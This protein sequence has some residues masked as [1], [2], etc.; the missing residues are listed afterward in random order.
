MWTP[1]DA[2]PPASR[3]AIPVAAPPRVRDL[4]RT[5]PDGPL[6]VLHRGPRAIY[7]AVG[8]RAV[9]LLAQT[10]VAV[11]NGLRSTISQF[12]PHQGLSAYSGSGVLHVD[13]RPLSVRRIVG[14]HIPP[15][16][17]ARSPSNT[18]SSATFAATPP[19]A[20]AEFVVSEAPDGIDAVAVA[21]LVGRGEGLTPLG[22]DVL[23]GWLA[24]HRA[25][26]VA[27]PDVDATVRAHA[28]RTT[29]LSATLLD[30]ALHG[31]GLPE[32]G[33]WLHALGSRDES[34]AATALLAV[35]GTSGAGLMA[36]AMLALEALR[37][38]RAPEVAA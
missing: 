19:A 34:P 20:V 13:G 35:G 11:P 31:E 17:Y 10:A 32:L 6:E 5:V 7:V 15:V 26:G 1:P 3:E 9:G 2:S 33:A 30:C 27:T 24:A 23:C 21:R 25:A 28:H 8:D 16:R 36:G 12:S 4:L 37:R 18:A 14:V 29:L 22:D 38:D